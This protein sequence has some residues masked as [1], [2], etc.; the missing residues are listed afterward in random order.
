MRGD[1]IAHGVLIPILGKVDIG[2]LAEGMHAGVGA[3][4]ATHLHSLAAEFFDRLRQHTLHRRPD[5]L[6]LPADE[7]RAVIFDAELVARHAPYQ[8]RRV[9]GAIGAPR[10]NASEGIAGRPA[11]CNS[12]TRTAPSPQAMVRRSSST[13]PGALAPSAR[14][15]RRILRRTGLPSLVNSHHAPGNGERPRM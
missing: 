5:V 2:D 1:R 6:D 8:P 4:G 10:R 7:P 13:V 9:P 11:R 3:P 12:S 15:V 14:V